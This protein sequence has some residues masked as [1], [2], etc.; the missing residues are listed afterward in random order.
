ML[1]P[2]LIDTALTTLAPTVPVLASTLPANTVPVALTWPPVDILAPVKLLVDEILLPV[3]LPLALTV[4]TNTL[5]PSML[6]LALTLAAFTKPA[7]ET[8]PTV[9]VPVAL[10]KPAVITLPAVALPVALT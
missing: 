9:A 7:V 5:L 4:L 8:F 10:I 3:M 2:A 1:P 6:P